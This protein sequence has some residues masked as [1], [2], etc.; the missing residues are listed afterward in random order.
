M[1]CGRY[2]TGKYRPKELF[3]PPKKTCLFTH[4]RIG[5]SPSP[6]TSIN[7]F[8]CPEQLPFAS[9]Q[10]NIRALWEV[11]KDCLMS[12]ATVPEVME[13][14]PHLQSFSIVQQYIK[15]RFHGV[16]DFLSTLDND[17]SQKESTGSPY[18]IFLAIAEM[19]KSKRIPSHIAL[20]QPN[21]TVSAISPS[22]LIA[23]YAVSLYDSATQEA[24][25]LDLI[26]RV[27]TVQQGTWEKEI[28]NVLVSRMA[29]GEGSRS[30]RKVWMYMEG[31]FAKWRA[32]FVKL[33]FS[34]ARDR[35]SA[36]GGSGGS[37][38]ELEIRSG[39]GNVLEALK[40]TRKNG[41]A[42][43]ISITPTSQIS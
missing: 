34:E 8:R 21:S 17:L 13:P 41:V 37:E 32:Q 4:I 25:V 3:K 5:Q 10:E 16:Q 12:L 43:K 31:C 1:D 18:K 29:E 20:S 7:V 11:Y 14:H 30:V 15:D 6:Q 22:N 33:G 2:R 24:F 26:L 39:W 23:G 28:L 40:L 36:D 35:S 38:E 9:L 42:M 27:P 19:P